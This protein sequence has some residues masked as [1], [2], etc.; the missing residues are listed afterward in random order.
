MLW[1]EPGRGSYRLGEAIKVGIFANGFED[2]PW[3]GERAF[4]IWAVNPS[5]VP[6]ELTVVPG[7]GE[8]C[9]AVWFLPGEMGVYTVAAAITGEVSFSARTYFPVEKERRVPLSQVGQ[10]LVIAPV[11]HEGSYLNWPVCLEVR[12]AGKPLPGAAVTVFPDLWRG[13]RLYKKADEDG[14]LVFDGRNWCY[15]QK[16]SEKK[17]GMVFFP[18]GINW[19]MLVDHT[20]PGGQRHV[21]ACTFCPEQV[22]CC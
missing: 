4:R 8:E 12:F 6:R 20:A 7:G 17:D 16:G 18:W 2:L 19:L 9:S 10:E 21:A 22:S 15:W 14:R 13:E 1:L 5:G 11:W 3:E